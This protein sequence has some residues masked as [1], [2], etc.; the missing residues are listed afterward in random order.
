MLLLYVVSDATDD[1]SDDEGV[2][3]IENGIEDEDIE[4]QG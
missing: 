3:L 4:D 2:G 1:V